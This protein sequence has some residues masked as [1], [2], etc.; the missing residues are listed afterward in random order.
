[1]LS[2]NKPLQVFV[3]VL[4]SI[5]TVGLETV[6]SG[7]LIGGETLEF[8]NTG[9]LCLLS[10][11]SVCAVMVILAFVCAKSDTGAILETLLV[12]KLISL[13]TYGVMAFVPFIGDSLGFPLVFACFDTAVTFVSICENFGDMTIATALAVIMAVILPILTGIIS[14]FGIYKKRV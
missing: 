1:M 4:V 11:I 13:V 14:Y 10:P 2:K 6:F 3:G 7:Y 5:F 12:C 9:F 8:L